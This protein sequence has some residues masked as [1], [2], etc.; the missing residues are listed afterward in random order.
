MR[1]PRSRGVQRFLDVIIDIGESAGQMLAPASS[2]V[3][4]ELQNMIDLDLHSGEFSIALRIHMLQGM[5]EVLFAKRLI[6]STSLRTN[7]CMQHL[8]VY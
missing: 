7:V 2:S 1:A 8:L 5:D 4:D 3:G 6:F